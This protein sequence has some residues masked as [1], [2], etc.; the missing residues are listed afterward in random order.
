MFLRKKKIT[1][2]FCC[3]VWISNFEASSDSCQPEAGLWAQCPEVFG[4]LFK[5]EVK[6]HTAQVRAH[7]WGAMVYL[8]AY[9]GLVYCL[10]FV[11]QSSREGGVQLL[12]CN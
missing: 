4:F 11:L 5:N 8:G 1:P 9:K 6:V 3:A 12:G 2:S 10:D 7:C